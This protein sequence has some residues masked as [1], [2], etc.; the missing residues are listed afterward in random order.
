MAK[1]C[2]AQAKKAFKESQ[3]VNGIKQEGKRGKKT[4]QKGGKKEADGGNDGESDARAANGTAAGA[5]QPGATEP[6]IDYECLRSVVLNHQLAPWF[7]PFLPERV[8]FADIADDVSNSVV[9]EAAQGTSE[10]GEGGNDVGSGGTT[11]S[12]GAGQGKKKAMV[13]VKDGATL[14]ENGKTKASGGRQKKTPKANGVA[15]EA[16][17]KKPK[18][19]GA[20]SG[21]VG[22]EEAGGRAKRSSKEAKPLSSKIAPAAKS[23]AV[24]RTPKKKAVPARQARGTA[25]GGRKGKA[26][27]TIGGDQHAESS[28][29][30]RAAAE[31]QA[32]STGHGKDRATKAPQ[33]RK[34][35][36]KK[37]K[38][39]GK[40]RSGVANGVKDK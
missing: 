36:V 38:S 21:E 13:T 33:P 5:S 30:G 8:P 2:I 15:A 37:D 34:A 25:A 19:R 14:S 4:K 40:G 39:R 11:G 24:T 12:D 35:A 20:T 26:H 31:P 16:Q 18:A 10:S 29:G 17:S 1:A 23:K 3:A 27:T 6:C 9:P 22:R 32:A 7:Q 28:G